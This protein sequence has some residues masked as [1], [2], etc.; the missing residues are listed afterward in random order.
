MNQLRFL[1]AR[2]APYR[3]DLLLIGIVT[4]LGSLST[5]AIPWLAGHLLGGVVAESG[6]VGA[7]VALLL[8]ALATTTALN[9]AAAILSA[10]ASARI[11]ADLRRDV[12][13]HVVALPTGF[14]DRSRQGDLLALMTYE[15]ASLSQFLAATLAT[16][17][18]MLLTA[19]GA[20]VLLFV[21]DPVAALA[22][23]VLVPAFYVLL[24]LVGRRLRWLSRA[25]RKAE[26]ML[27]AE[28]ESHLEILPAIKAFAAE[29]RQQAA[30]DARVER[31]RRASVAQSRIDAVIG[32]SI[33]LVAAIAAIAV[34]VL[35]GRQ[36]GSG[37]GNPSQVFSF[38][39]Y[40]ALLT[41][42][43]GALADVYGRYQIA[44]GSLSRLQAVLR[45]R[46]EPGLS[47]TG[48]PGPVRGEIAFEDVHFAYPGRPKTLA[49]AS[50][51]VAAGETVA[52]VGENGAG[53][54]TLISLLMRFYEPG[55]G[56]IMLDGMDIAAM[57][58]QSLRRQLGLVPQRALLFNGSIREN[59]AFGLKD[60]SDD[61]VAQAAR[62][63]QATDF[64]SALPKGLA[65]QIGDHGVRLSGGQRQRIALARALVADP[66][67][68]ILDEA[69]AMYD[70]DG[71]AAFVESCRSALK[72][73]TVLIITH[74]PA[75]LALADRVLSV[76]SGQVRDLADAP[77]AAPRDG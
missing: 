7:V 4:V 21:I 39:L 29:D 34:L 28:A 40:A 73:R 72:G 20:V 12:H 41:R 9:V 26:A 14:H 61:Q 23:P 10:V 30:Y 5:L 1:L 53:K 71:E 70:L 43:I 49:G 67:V 55:A 59:I 11:L 37:Q 19:G 74:R 54:S 42:P 38:L 35:A 33:G 56:R 27:F 65:T 45:E 25:T 51:R 17:P 22:I 68:L 2:A 31:A 66:P 13:A 46:A 52:L 63:A 16:A 62:M 36:L 15:V 44:R 75:S 58:V 47:A 64:I 69:T 6:G 48:E 3:T 77:R 57:H 32:P 8:A 76:E 50:F 24:K 60:A 18:S